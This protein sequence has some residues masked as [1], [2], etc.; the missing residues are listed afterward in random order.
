MTLFHLPVYKPYVPVL[1]PCT[2]VLSDMMKKLLK[3]YLMYSIQIT[4]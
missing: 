1:K 4:V 3:N 2:K